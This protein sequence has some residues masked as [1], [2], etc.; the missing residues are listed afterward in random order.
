MR[1]AALQ[2][3]GALLG[4][5]PGTPR[6]VEID[7][8]VHRIGLSLAALSEDGSHAVRTEVAA[9]LS[10]LVVMYKPYFQ[11]VAAKAKEEER[12]QKSRR[13]GQQDPFSRLLKTIFMLAADPFPTVAEIASVLLS[14]LGIRAGARRRTTSRSRGETGDL[15]VPATPTSAPATSA[16]NVAIRDSVPGTPGGLGGTP[17][18]P[19]LGSFEIGISG[20]YASPALGWC[21][22]YVRVASGDFNHQ[23]ASSESEALESLLTVLSHAIGVMQ[24]REH[25]MATEEQVNLAQIN[26][27]VSGALEAVPGLRSSMHAVGW[28]GTRFANSL[29][30]SLLQRAHDVTRAHL[31]DISESGQAN[32]LRLCQTHFFDW[33][34][35]TFHLWTQS[36]DSNPFQEVG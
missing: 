5:R 23:R 25:A 21:R 27:C 29:S 17:P 8:N 26:S 4:P 32:R 1:A 11:G 36:G 12:L 30:S 13:D 19:A 15:S 28:Q 33:C 22:D 2:A 20:S 24:A 16:I 3:L 9:A 35:S 31:I 18:T 34:T 7:I 14:H 6:D 10:P